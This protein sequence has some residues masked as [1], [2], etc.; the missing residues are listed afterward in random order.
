M[1]TNRFIRH[2]IMGASLALLV[3]FPAL[4]AQAGDQSSGKS[5]PSASTAGLSIAASDA[6]GDTLKAC[7]ARIPK[8][9]S[10]GQRMIAEQGCGRDEGNRK[11]IQSVPG[12]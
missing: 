5:T 3:G 8:D 7:L 10:A 1:E 6:V 11:S 4:P 9:S 2:M 12:H